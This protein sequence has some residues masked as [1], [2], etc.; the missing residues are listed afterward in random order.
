MLNTNTLSLM[1]STNDRINFNL[2][3]QLCPEQAGFRHV[4]YMY[5]EYVWWFIDECVWWICM[6]NMHDDSLMNA[7]DEYV[8]FIDECVW[9]ICMMNM[10]DDSLMNAYDEYVWWICMM[11]MYDEYVW[12]FIDECVWWICMMNMY[13]NSLMNAYDEYVWWLCMMNM[14]VWWIKLN[15]NEQD[16]NGLHMSKEA[17]ARAPFFMKPEWCPP[18][19]PGPVIPGEWCMKHFEYAWFICRLCKIYDKMMFNCVWGIFMIK[20]TMHAEA[21]MKYK[22]RNRKTWRERMCGWWHNS[23]R[24]EWPVFRDM[25]RDFIKANV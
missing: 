9:W 23:P 2:G 15:M 3:A 11:N 22:G 19:H 4:E 5:D 13:D 18:Q 20:I 6:M 16:R 21:G 17:H 24:P 12:W 14:H 10:Y 25:W 1:Y 7:Y 8:W